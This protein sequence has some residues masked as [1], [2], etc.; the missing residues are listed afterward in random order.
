M[1]RAFEEALAVLE[2]ER[3]SVGWK[4]KMDIALEAKFQCSQVV[5]EVVLACM[6]AVG[7]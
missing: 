5:I 6:G 3:E 1:R 7:I 2:M 4:Q